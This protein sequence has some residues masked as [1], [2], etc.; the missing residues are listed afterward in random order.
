LDAATV[1]RLYPGGTS[2]YLE[3][4]T[5]SLDSAI[6]SGFIVAADRDEILQLAATTFP[7]AGE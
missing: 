3:R 7:A 2:E 4:F 6:R 1:R 5:A